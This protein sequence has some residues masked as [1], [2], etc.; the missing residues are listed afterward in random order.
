M[1]NASKALIIAGAILLAILLIS[2]GIYIFTGA[3]DVTKNTGLQTQEAATFNASILDA[4]EVSVFNSAM[5]K[6]EGKNK[7]ASDIRAIKNEAIAANKKLKQEGKAGTNNADLIKIKVLTA[8]PVVASS[9]DTST[10]SENE[11]K[12]TIKLNY[13]D[14]TGYVNLI[15][16]SQ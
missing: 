6:Y 10:L 15:T 3:Q 9:A 2:L 4:Q 5:V 1:E 11:K 12:Y 8:N 13:N 16:I 7:S 14:T